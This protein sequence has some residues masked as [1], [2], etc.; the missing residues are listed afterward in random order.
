MKFLTLFLSF[1]FAIHLPAQQLSMLS[2][3]N[4][5][6]LRGLSVVSDRVVWVSGSGGTVGLSTDSGISW[7]WIQVPRYEKTDFRDIQ[8]FSDS[9]A[10]IMGITQPAVILKTKDGGK[11]WIKTFE[12]SSQSVFLDAMDFSGDKGM[13]LGD[14]ISS[15]P[16]LAETK[17]RGDSW[18]MLRSHLPNMEA[19]EAFFAASGSNIKWLPIGHFVFVSGGKRSALYIDTIAKLPLRLMQGKETTG[20]NSIAV[21]PSNPN[22]AF[23]VGGD[24]SEDSLNAGNAV[25]INLFPLNQELP[26]APPHGY[27][28]CVIYLNDKTLISC[29]TSG[30][31]ISRDGGKHWKP[32]SASGFH[33]CAKAAGGNIVY[34]AGPKGKV[35][36]LYWK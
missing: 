17:D 33:V 21:N 29:G 6:S 34:L 13:L 27:R 2:M 9:E 16:F 3:T 7:N 19:G 36:R 28:S 15:R 30:V 1:L 4:T 14:P 8:A 31:D 23:I 10:V 20:A 5:S 26:P 24:F 12:D 25:L 32:I 18:T 11:T 35:A 22:Q